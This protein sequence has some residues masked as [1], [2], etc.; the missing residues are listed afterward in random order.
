[1]ASTTKMIPIGE[2]FDMQQLVNQLVQTYRGKGFEVQAMQMGNAV[3]V[4]FSKDD[5]GIKKFAGLALGIK[6][7]LSVSNNMLM[8]SFSDAEWT[9]KII[10]IAVGWILCLIPLF[11]GAYGAM[12]QS[13][14]PNKI[15]DDIQM[16]VNGAAPMM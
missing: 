8:V 12:Q 9:G 7:M 2:G 11:T 13:G 10:A 4:T 5:E 6:A 16:I 14:L 15:G 3:S 1:M